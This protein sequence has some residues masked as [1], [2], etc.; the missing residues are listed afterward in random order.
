MS[1]F[2]DGAYA[3][4]TQ[5]RLELGGSCGGGGTGGDIAALG[6]GR[7]AVDDVDGQGLAVF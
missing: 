5:T 7:P 3:A 6:G 2:K 1:T 4:L